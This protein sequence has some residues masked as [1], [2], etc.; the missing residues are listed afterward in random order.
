MGCYGLGVSR[1]LAA[2]VQ[3]NADDRGIV[4]P[5]GMSPISAMIMVASAPNKPRYWEMRRAAEQ[6][7][8]HMAQFAPSVGDVIMD[9]RDATTSV[10]ERFAHAD[11]IGY[12]WVVVV[13]K[14]W[15]AS[16]K[17]GDGSQA[18]SSANDAEEH[19]FEVQNRSKTVK[20]VV[21]GYAELLKVIGW[22]N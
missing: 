10:G 9:D 13:G 21:R 11:L 18:T 6:L 5:R 14:A 17:P 4:W 19:D 15:A 1:L 16:A 22:K 12:E 8:D 20:R 2:L 3:V 7:Y